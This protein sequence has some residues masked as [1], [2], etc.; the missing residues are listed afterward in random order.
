MRIKRNF[1]ILL[2]S[3]WGPIVT[4]KFGSVAN[5]LKCANGLAL[6]VTRVGVSNMMGFLIGS[7]VKLKPIRFNTGKKT[8]LRLQEHQKM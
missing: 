8:Y 4:I 5:K 7:G 3:K 6:R 2:K 1:F